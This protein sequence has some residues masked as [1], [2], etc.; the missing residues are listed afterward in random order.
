MKTN[1]TR[2]GIAVRSS[3]NKYQ[4]QPR[5]RWLA[6]G[7]ALSVLIAGMI[8]TPLDAQ[9]KLTAAAA[10]DGKVQLQLLGKPGGVYVVQATTDLTNWVSLST[11]TATLTGLLSVADSQ[12]ASFRQRFYRGIVLNEPKLIR[13]S[14]RIMVKPNP[15]VDL[16][17][18]ESALGLRLV[19]SFSGFNNLRVLELTAGVNSQDLAVQRAQAF[20]IGV[21]TAPSGKDKAGGFWQ[22]NS[23]VGSKNIMTTTFGTGWAT[24]GLMRTLPMQGDKQ[25]N[26]GSPTKADPTPVEAKK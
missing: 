18:L 12:A 21:Q 3:K 9:V 20:L 8:N 15:G 13:Q 19:Y 5:I 7:A 23:R 22:V 11:N 10:A 2:N 26:T 4:F 6:A 25:G 24:L 16:S 1:P 17:A 14:T